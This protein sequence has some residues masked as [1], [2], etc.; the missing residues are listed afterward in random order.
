[1]MVSTAPGTGLDTE[2][3]DKAGT[4]QANRISMMPRDNR[5]LGVL[6]FL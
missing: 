3:V 6:D 2:G 4:W 5:I 1:M